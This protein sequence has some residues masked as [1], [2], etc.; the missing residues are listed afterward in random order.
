MMMK[1]EDGI[2]FVKA[3]D[4]EES[5]IRS[6]RLMTKDRKKNWWYGKVSVE[7]LTKIY[8]NFGLTKDAADE[9]KRL[10]KIRRAVDEE[11]VKPDAELK[12]LVKYP[13]KTNL[14]AHQVRAANMA[15][16]IF[17]IAGGK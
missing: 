4:R 10:V 6:W 5:I 14:Y 8:Q 17:E 15:L 7:L 1:L 11:R 16:M 9:L 13:V 3:D 12:P 2:V